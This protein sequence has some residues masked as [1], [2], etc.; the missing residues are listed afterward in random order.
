M[1]CLDLN[2]SQLGQPLKR[3]QTSGLAANRLQD[4]LHTHF[5]RIIGLRRFA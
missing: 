1:D 5:P 3:T 4:K 2:G